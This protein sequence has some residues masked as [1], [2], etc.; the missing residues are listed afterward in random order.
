[1]FFQTV[2]FFQSL[3]FLFVLETATSNSLGN[4]LAKMLLTSG[5]WLVI[6]GFLAVACYF[7]FFSRRLAGS[8]KSHSIVFVFFISS[9]GLLYF[10]NSVI[11]Q[12]ILIGILTGAF[13]FL[14][15]AFYRLHKYKKDKTALGIFSAASV[16]SMF[17]FY[18]F[19]LAA[20]LNFAIP[21]WFL[22][23]AF[24]LVTTSVSYQSFY[25]LIEDK[26]KAINFALVIGFAMAEIAWLINFWPFG[27]LT[28]A[29]ISLI[30]YYVFWDMMQSNFSGD[31][32]KQ[33]VLAHLI[34]LSVMLLMVLTSSHWL[35][36][37]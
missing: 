28:T 5:W 1:M 16:A 14:E 23:V 2:I 9:L 34:S 37:F 19:S 7:Y 35:P 8:I 10:V 6:G 33:R 3:L 18:A 4:Y 21:I 20:Y 11:E 30:F 32:T 13:Y 25:L 36:V 22:M 12:N 31:L 24:L 15:L 17:L 27:Y 29:V 26:K